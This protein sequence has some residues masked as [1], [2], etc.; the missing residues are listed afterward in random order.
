MAHKVI[1]FVKADGGRFLRRLGKDRARTLG[2]VRR[3][4][5]LMAEPKIVLEKTKQALR[6][7]ARNK[8]SPKGTD[9]KRE[10]VK[11]DEILSTQKS[12]DSNEALKHRS[13]AAD[14]ATLQ[15]ASSLIME[16]KVSSQPVKGSRNGQKTIN[17][18]FSSA[19]H[20]IHRGPQCV[21]ISTAASN[22]LLQLQL[23]DQLR[24]DQ[25]ESPGIYARASPTPALELLDF[26]Q[27]GSPYST[28]TVLAASIQAMSQN[29][30]LH[31]PLRTDVG[32]QNALGLGSCLP[33][34]LSSN[35]TLSSRRTDQQ[36]GNIGISPVLYS[37][38]R[39]LQGRVPIPETSST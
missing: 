12:T 38:L 24:R 19:S 37:L 3:D 9:K 22:I 8:V 34:I 23:A 30:I 17:H 20:P 1:I 11:N 16:Q 39:N 15:N 35:P 5:F 32:L 29:N 33:G 18:A 2:F 31:L 28:P 25:E 10:I 26:Q 7:Q 27:M 14:D 21:S 6:F 13:V 36:N 4:A